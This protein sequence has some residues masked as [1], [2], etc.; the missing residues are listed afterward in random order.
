MKR[1]GKNMK[2]II[3]FEKEIDFPSM[4]G[5]I[6]SISIDSSLKFIDE[7]NVEGNLSVFGTYKM[8][9]ASK[10]E[11]DRYKLRLRTNNLIGEKIGW[12]FD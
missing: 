10:L 1:E 5:E 9:E 12:D 6:S 3:S 4:I 8:T 2:K 11:E 7:S